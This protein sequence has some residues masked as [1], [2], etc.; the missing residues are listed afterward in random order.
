[1]ARRM[2]ESG[3]IGR[4]NCRCSKEDK[5]IRPF[6]IGTQP[7]MVREILNISSFTTIKNKIVKHKTQISLHKNTHLL[8][9]GPN[10]IGKTTIRKTI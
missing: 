6:I 10:G 8:L 1:M 3:R 5:S 2:R 4:R 9:Q 7:N